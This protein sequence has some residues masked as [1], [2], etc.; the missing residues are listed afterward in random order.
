[1][2]EN[3]LKILATFANVIILSVMLGSGTWVAL[4]ARKKGRTTA[5]IISWFFFSAMFILIGPLVYVYFR[6]RFYK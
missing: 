4:D 3:E 2:N 1:M 5:E 6:N